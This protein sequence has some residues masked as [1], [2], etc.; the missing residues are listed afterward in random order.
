MKEGEKTCSFFLLL[1]EFHARA[2]MRTGP[3][4]GTDGEPFLLRSGMSSSPRKASCS[5]SSL[6]MNASL[7]NE[8]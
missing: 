3:A 6:Q 4:P 7:L 5:L 8:R 2:R 1:K